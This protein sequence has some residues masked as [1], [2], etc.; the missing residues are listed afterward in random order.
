MRLR[1]VVFLQ[2]LQI[3]GVV[4][5][6][7][8]PPPPPPSSDSPPP[9]N[10]VTNS[11]TQPNSTSNP[12]PLL[13][14]T[15]SHVNC[16]AGF[17]QVGQKCSSCYTGCS[18]CSGPAKEQCIRCIQGLIQ[19]MSGLCTLSCE[20]GFYVNQENQCAQCSDSC[21]NGCTEAADVCN[22]CSSSNGTTTYFS[23]LSNTCVESCPIYLFTPDPS[24]NRCIPIPYKN[25]LQGTIDGKCT[26]CESWYF[27]DEIGNCP[28]QCS[29]G[30]V[31]CSNPES[32]WKCAE[33]WTLNPNSTCSCPYSNCEIC[34]NSSCVTCKDGYLLQEN[35]ECVQLKANCLYSNDINSCVICKSGFYFN[36]TDCMTCP[37][38]CRWCFS[39][40]CTSCKEGFYLDDS[41]ACTL[42]TV[43]PSWVVGI[44][45]G[46][47]SGSLLVFILCGLCLNPKDC[48]DPFRKVRNVF[49]KNGKGKARQELKITITKSNSPREIELEVKEKGS[50]IQLNGGSELIEEEVKQNETAAANFNDANQNSEIPLLEILRSY[51]ESQSLEGAH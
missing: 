23:P 35:K 2:I 21:P 30:C 47:I 11:S 32:C 16:G 9:P 26:K 12:Q 5:Q 49:K 46:S 50:Q 19:N 44:I 13:P 40:G 3:T 34:G 39:G 15:P 22:P 42:G 45:L 28:V 48:A 51:A 25:C 37:T 4:T 6:P 1:L 43:D 10:N 14:V 29:K 38:G 7:P 41:L 8:N 31:N 33:G 27:L 20:S 18:T 17:Y 24:T 36:G